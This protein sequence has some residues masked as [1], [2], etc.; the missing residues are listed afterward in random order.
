MPFDFYLC[1][2]TEDKGF[3]IPLADALK[4]AGVSVWL[5]QEQIRPGDSLRRK[6]D[7]GLKS[8]RRGIVVVS[9]RLFK[10]RTPRKN[11]TRCSA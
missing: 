9:K 5:D 6:M 10:K 3:V 7:D 11:W 4:A 8:S 2:A 1:H